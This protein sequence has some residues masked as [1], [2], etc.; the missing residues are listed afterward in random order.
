MISLSRLITSEIR[1]S[2]LMNEGII[3]FAGPLY[4]SEY[5]IMDLAKF[6]EESLSK[7]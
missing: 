5:S 2:F 6:M 7:T 4:E 3:C 1:K